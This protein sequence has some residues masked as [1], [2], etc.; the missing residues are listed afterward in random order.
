MIG[1]DIHTYG[2]LRRTH[3][4]RPSYF[5]FRVRHYT[6]SIEKLET[7]V[8]VKYLEINGYACIFLKLYPSSRLLLLGHT[9]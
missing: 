9:I 4:Y 8:G 3:A 5:P 2:A 1:L 6:G 7:K